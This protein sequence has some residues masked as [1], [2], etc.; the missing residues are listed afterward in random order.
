MCCPAPPP[1]TTRFSRHAALP[2]PPSPPIQR[3][4]AA[5]ACLD[6]APPLPC[7]PWLLALIH[8]P[9]A[10]RPPCRFPAMIHRLSP[11]PIA[12]VEA[13]PH[14]TIADRILQLSVSRCITIRQFA[15]RQFAVRSWAGFLFPA[16]LFPRRFS[17]FS[18]P[19]VRG[20]HGLFPPHASHASHGLGGWVVR[21]LGCAMA[22]WGTVLSVGCGCG[23]GCARTDGFL[24]EN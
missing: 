20:S 7:P 3:W 11:S 16:A 22:A 24:L 6:P 14:R 9:T 5:A 13:H 23:A 17:Q 21:M 2:S 8:H 10:Y 15:V 4:P 19:A 18:Q 12:A 1:T